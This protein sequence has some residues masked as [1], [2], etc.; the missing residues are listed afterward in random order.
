MGVGSLHERGGLTRASSVHVHAY[1]T[2]F[3]ASV[4]FPSQARIFMIRHNMQARISCQC[5][6]NN[7]LYH[8]IVCIISPE[9]PPPNKL[10][11][12][13]VLAQR[14]LVSSCIV[15][16]PITIIS[17]SCSK[18]LNDI[19]LPQVNGNP[20]FVIVV[21]EWAPGA[22]GFVR[23]RLSEHSRIFWENC[24]CVLIVKIAG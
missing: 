10:K 23:N 14:K 3:N 20:F 19:F 15:V 7:M 17:G 5:C 9:N 16:M 6:L 2:F 21:S 8:I 22:C 11:I 12:H 13:S 18:L 1:F 24:V 4:D